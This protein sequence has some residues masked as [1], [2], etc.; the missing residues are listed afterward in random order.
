MRQQMETLQNKLKAKLLSLGLN[1]EAEAL[2]D[3][4]LA[5]NSIDTVVGKI[6]DRIRID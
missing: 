5:E 1:G 2:G 3:T 4:N 6:F